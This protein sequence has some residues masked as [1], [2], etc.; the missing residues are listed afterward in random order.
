MLA[1]TGF[2]S[3]E[4]KNLRWSE[5]DFERGIATL[6]ETKT[7]LSVRPLSR[8]AIEIIKRQ[9]QTSSF[10]FAYKHGKPVAI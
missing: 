3:G 8:A 10:V 7:G 5:I 4:I 6:G 1:I 2:R 9:P